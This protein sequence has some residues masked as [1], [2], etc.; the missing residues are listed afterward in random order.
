MYNSHY[1]QHLMYNSH[2]IQ[3]PMY[4]S[5]YIP[6]LMYNSHYIPHHTHNEIIAFYCN[7]IN[8]PHIPILQIW[9]ATKIHR[10]TKSGSSNAERKSTL[11]MTFNKGI[12]PIITYPV[13][14]LRPWE[15]TESWFLSWDHQRVCKLHCANELIFSV[16]QPALWF[17]LELEHWSSKLWLKKKKKQNKNIS[18]KKST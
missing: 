18:I 14:P 9:K 7:C 1:I 12:Q 10:T 11:Q 6:H 13:F 2:Y 4:N 5:H 15:V 17:Y 3:H 16:T 8:F